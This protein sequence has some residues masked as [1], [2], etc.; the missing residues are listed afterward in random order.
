VGYEW[1][2]AK[3]QDVYSAHR[4]YVLQVRPI[5]DM[6][7]GHCLAT[8]LDLTGEKPKQV[9]SRHLINDYGADRIYVADSGRYV[10]TLGDWGPDADK[11]PVVVYGDDGSLL[12]PFS[13]EDLG[14]K[15]PADQDDP[16]F[17]WFWSDDSISFFG[18]KEETFIIRLAWR[19]YVMVSLTSPGAMN[20]DWYEVHK[21][22]HTTEAEWKAL[23][24]F[25]EKRVRELAQEM[26][27]SPSRVDRQAGAVVC[28][29]LGLEESRE[30]LRR[31]LMDDAS[32][33][34]KNGDGP[35]TKVFHVRRAAKEALEAM[36]EKVEGVVVEV[37]DPK[38]LP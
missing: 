21:G 8:L 19:Q 34:T 26:L 2:P 35:W 37:P 6:K 27:T 3:T 36:G 20:A 31:L 22:W 16:S 7:P 10:V 18:P 25:R 29:Q 14:I 11:L 28:G 9:W 15:K 30:K 13:I 23:H 17:V 1:S 24:L 38:P 12:R 32:Y 33:E 5:E 4:K